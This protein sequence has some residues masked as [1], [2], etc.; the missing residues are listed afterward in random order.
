[1]AMQMVSWGRAAKSELELAPGKAPSRQGELRRSMA[2]LLTCLM[3][4]C[5]PGLASKKQPKA[6]K[7]TEPS[8]LDQYVEE[9]A[10]QAREV[11]PPTPGSLWQAGAPLANLVRD[12][13]ASQLNDLVTITVNENLSAL[14][15]G[16][17]KTARTSATS[18]TVGA[19]G[20][21]YG[22][23]SALANLASLNGNSSLN[24]EGS[25]MRQ[26]SLTTSMS[27]RVVGVLPNGYLVVEGRKTVQVNTER[28]I[29]VVRGVIR[30]VDLASDN[31]VQSDHMAQME[32]SVN[33]KG[34]VGDAIRRPALL[35]RLLMGL[36]PF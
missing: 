18:A 16:T 8:A 33:G 35:Y 21:K 31:S 17:T 13:R 14:S 2:K 22:G 10:R 6:A 5:A 36:L 30:P 12:P 4:L 26:T 28:Q 3:L 24:G 29:I 34:V 11:A 23:S 20:H 25:T 19:L 32:V 27:A 7:P 15:S 9:A 1:M